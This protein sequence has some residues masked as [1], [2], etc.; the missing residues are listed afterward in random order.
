MKYGGIIRGYGVFLQFFKSRWSRRE[1][2]RKKYN[3][4]ETT[5]WII[6]QEVVFIYCSYKS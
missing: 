5:Y 3:M 2:L 1:S 6:I 4:L